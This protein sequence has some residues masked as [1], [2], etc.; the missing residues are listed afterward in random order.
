MCQCQ[1]CSRGFKNKGDLNRHLQ[2]H[3]EGWYWCDTCPYKNKDK[4]NRDS[5]MRI[6]QKQGT[7]LEHYKCKQCGKAMRYS[8]QMHCHKKA[9]CQLIDLRVQTEKAQPT[10]K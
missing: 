8:T 5:H 1:G 9:G 3:L 2:S 7:G 4:Q 6:H 10:D